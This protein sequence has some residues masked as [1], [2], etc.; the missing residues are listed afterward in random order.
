MKEEQ[1]PSTQRIGYVSDIHL[2]HLLRNKKASS[3][4]AIDGVLETVGK[5]FLEES[6]PEDV[7][8]IDGDTCLNFPLFERFVS[9]LGDTGRTFV[10]T[11]GNHD[12]W[13]C[14][15]DTVD[16][17]AEKYRAFLRSRGMYLLHNDVLYFEGAGQPPERI[18]EEELREA[19]EAEL[20]ERTAEAK[21]ILFGGTGFAGYEP[22]FNARLGLYRYNKTIGLSREAELRETQR[23][24]ALY[25]RACAAFR[26]RKTVVATHMPLEDW[27]LPARQKHE[28]WKKALK[29]AKN[30]GEAPPGIPGLLSAC[31]PGFVYVSGHTH[32]D[33]RYDDGTIRFFADN[34]FGY[35]K[36]APEA[37]PHL[38]FFEI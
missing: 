26:G 27:Y 37:W 3:E 34:Q 25:V 31:E 21:L 20:R 35:Q 17:L 18:P 5:T 12:I 4:E 30:G 6:A 15:E 36:D 2:F 24:E 10:F 38:K 9:A 16:E 28:S 8:L 11:I 14:P 7:I 32:M 19:P 1:S 33:F 23:F 22:L 29:Q 13:S